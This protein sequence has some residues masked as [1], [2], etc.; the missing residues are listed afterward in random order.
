MPPRLVV[1][2]SLGAV[3]A[4]IESRTWHTADLDAT[5]PD[6][7]PFTADAIAN[8]ND[9]AHTLAQYQKLAEAENHR[10]AERF[11]YAVAAYR[12][13]D[14]QYGQALDD[15]DRRHAID[16]I[17]L[18]APSRPLPPIPVGPAAPRSLDA[19]AY[20]DV[21]RTHLLLAGGDEGASL[22]STQANAE[23]AADVILS[24]DPPQSPT[25]W[26]GDAARAAYT[27]MNSFNAW[28][29]DLAGGWRR[30]GDAAAKIKAAHDTAYTR[31][32]S[33]WA[34]Y[35]AE[36]DRLA[37]LMADCGHVGS[38]VRTQLEIKR[39]YAKMAALQRESDDIRE[40]YANGAT[41]D[42]IR[43]SPPPF[44]SDARPPA[45]SA[46]AGGAG[47]GGGTRMAPTP[48][49][50]PSLQSEETMAGG[51]P[52]TGSVPSI[53]DS[54]QGGGASSGGGGS[55]LGGALS[56]VSG[57][58]GPP[59]DRTRE[60]P[61]LSA[62][63]GVHPATAGAGTSSPMPLQPSVGG[64]SVGPA[65]VAPGTPGGAQ[66]AAMGALG[67]AMGGGGIGAP[68]HG[69]G[70]GEGREKRRTPGLSPDEALYVEDR[71]YTE[72]VIGT[73]KRRTVQDPKD[74]T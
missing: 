47:R 25:D 12:T 4:A 38:G 48:P 52:A 22:V 68:V 45:T 70:Q 43:V 61:G 23:T 40:A 35:L 16:A 27:R 1:P 10:L 62:D 58:P 17:T 32:A 30:L 50:N 46:A 67:G 64:V 51:T 29:G 2:E 44:G 74:S 63:S 39:V 26:E 19:S 53:G 9:S 20:S 72:E 42:P 11:T 13:I 59:K 31:H 36:R 41:F 28:L 18:P 71:E 56:P 8:L 3:A 69:R 54:D 37:A 33:V 57:R 73:R 6:A 55:P 14:G 7:L 15:Q 5:P 21:E 49:K 24:H 65:P 66:P 34:Q 60:P